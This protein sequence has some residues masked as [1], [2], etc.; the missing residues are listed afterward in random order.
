MV[1]FAALYTD[2]FDKRAE[3]SQ[4]IKSTGSEGEF[5]YAHMRTCGVFLYSPYTEYFAQNDCSLCHNCIMHF[6]LIWLCNQSQ[7][8]NAG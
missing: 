4:D 5:C 7:G 6:L 2:Y 8:M 3:S 1:M